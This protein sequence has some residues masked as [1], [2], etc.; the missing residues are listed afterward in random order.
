MENKETA[1]LTDSLDKKNI[2]TKDSHNQCPLNALQFSEAKINNIPHEHEQNREKFLKKYLSDLEKCEEKIKI[3]QIISY[4][5]LLIF[6]I[7]LLSK[8]I[9]QN[10][11]N[12]SITFYIVSIPL[13][14]GII[15]FAISLNFFLRVKILIEKEESEILQNDESRNCSLGN[16]LSYFSLNLIALLFCTFL[17]LLS[18]KLEAKNTINP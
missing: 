2:S 14:F 8:S 9:I 10:A 17:I 12:N 6:L 1:L 5:S 4:I 7:L 18:I 15:N 11:G 3:F 16:F 13:I